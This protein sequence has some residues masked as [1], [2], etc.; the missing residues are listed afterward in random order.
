MLV[1]EDMFNLQAWYEHRF[2]KRGKSIAHARS[3]RFWQHAD[4][5][6]LLRI[7]SQTPTWPRSWW[8]SL[9]TWKLWTARSSPK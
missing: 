7:G 3:A 4:G 6:T 5:E 2:A 9:R 1:P 8:S